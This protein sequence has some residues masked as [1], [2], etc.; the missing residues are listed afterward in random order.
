MESSTASP[1]P[2][3][4]LESTP[5]AEY[6]S[7]IS[8]LDSTPA[9]CTTEYFSWRQLTDLSEKVPEL[10]ERFGPVTASF[11]G[12]CVAL[13]TESGAVAVVDY[14]GRIK[15]VLA[16]QSSSYGA[17][18]AV[19]FSADYTMLVAGYAQGFVAVWDW[20]KGT[21]VSVSRPLQ[22]TDKADVVGHPAGVAVTGVQFIGTSKHRYISCSAGGSVFYHHIVR[23][24]LTT[25]STKQ[26]SSIESSAD[27]LFEAAPLPGGSYICETDGL[28][29]VA[30]LSSSSVAVLKTR[31]GVEQ[32]YRQSYQRPRRPNTATHPEAAGMRTFAK[33][34]YSG[35]VSWLPALKTKSAATATDP[36]ENVY[37]LPRLLFSWGPHIC[38][39]SAVLDHAVAENGAPLV[40]SRATPRVK[41]EQT[42]EWGAIEDVVFCRW[43][44]AETFL[45]MTRTQRLF[46]FE[47]KLH[48]ETEICISPPGIIAGRPWVT[49]ATGNEAEPSY[50]QVMNVYR[51]RVFSLC[52]ATSVYTGR[53]LSWTERLAL[54]LDQGH[55]ID[56]ITLATGLFHGDTG[57][58]VVGLPRSRRNGDSNERRRHSL[59]GNKLAELMRSALKHMFGGEDTQTQGQRLVTSPVS[60]TGTASGF[61]FGYGFESGSGSGSGS[62]RRSDS[63]MRALVSACI[64]ACLATDTM[65]ILFG[66]VYECYAGS[67][68]GLCAY[69]ETLEPFILCGRVTQLP[70]QILNAFIDA[71]GST[72]QMVRRLGEILMNLRLTQGDFDIDRVLGSCRRYGLWRTFARVWLGLGDP[73]TPVNSMV[74]ALS[75]K[76][77]GDD[78]TSSARGSSCADFRDARES[79]EVPEV[80]LYD[81]IDMVLRGRH[82][83]DGQPIRPQSRAEKYSTQIAELVLLPADKWSSSGGGDGGGGGTHSEY[84]VLLTLLDIDTERF[85]L[86]LKRVLS[87]PF[88]DYINLIIKPDLAALAAGGRMAKGSDRSLRRASQVKSFA[89][90]V[91][92]TFYALTVEGGSKANHS[93]P[94]ELL[95]KH[96]V[97]LLSSFA[98]TLYST[99][100]PLIFLCD[101]KVTVWTDLLLQL[102]DPTTLAEREYAFELMFKLNPPQSSAAWVDR[103]R[104]A[105]FFRVLEDI[106]Q[107]MRRYDLALQTYLD[108]PDFM[109]HRQVFAAIGALSATREAPALAD[110]AKFVR[111]RAVALVDIDAEGLVGVVESVEPLSHD[112]L[113]DA[114]ESDSKAQYAYLRALLDPAP[115]ALSRSTAALSRQR[116]SLT[117]VA[118]AA[119]ERSPP[120]IGL[121]DEQ[122]AV[123][124]PFRFLAPEG[125]Q[126]PNKFPPKYHERYLELLCQYNPGG[127]LGYLK[128]HADQSPEP[129]Q[130][131]H[132][133]AICSKHGVNDGLVWVLVRLGDFSGAL[134]TL[135]AQTDLVF[136][137]AKA[138]IPVDQ[139]SRADVAGAE[140]LSE[141][142][143]ER[144]V[145]HLNAASRS[146]GGCV[147][148][149]KAALA[150]LS[151]DVAALSARRPAG[152]EAV[153]DRAASDQARDDAA[154]ARSEHRAQAG[155]QLCDLWLLL[156]K[157]VLAYLH[158]TG[159]RLDGLPGD[160]AVC[161]RE[162]LQL[163]SKRQRWMLHDILDVL[164]SAASPAASLI[165]LRHIIQQLLRAEDA[166]SAADPATALVAR[167]RAAARSLDIAEIQHLLAVAVGAYKAEARLMA[168]TNVLVDHDLFTTVAQLVRAQKQGWLVS[169]DAGRLAAQNSSGSVA[170]MARNG[171]GGGLCCGAC[172]L[173]LF[174]DRRHSAAMAGWR[175][176]MT[177]YFESSSMRVID[178]HVFEDPAAQWQWI[179]LR[180]ASANYDEF[181][182]KNSAARHG[183]DGTGCGIGTGIGAHGQQQESQQVV[184]FKCG[185]GFHRAC[186]PASPALVCLRCSA[187]ATRETAAA[188]C[189]RDR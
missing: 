87:D 158:D 8:N 166:A 103:V 132:V 38:V 173:Q 139:E 167:P 116:S 110:I 107:G 151:R 11:M 68:A 73:V 84:R 54:L 117:A 168:L 163:I 181:R 3:L 92:D 15:T 95:S 142:D 170:G 113:F 1:M 115:E 159:R 149:C 119:D 105:G 5:E 27:V 36:A 182:S 30:I 51:R 189:L 37:S 141:A 138:A 63:E 45:Y 61:G 19:S 172:N 174:V 120:D 186:L 31:N 25:M 20:A 49:L 127:V 70:P 75:N 169:A 34:P 122:H 99:R 98:L 155:A 9:Q 106:Y 161:T 74:Q 28:G 160:C 146:I 13:G 18:S 43:I 121:S 65:P 126:T 153:S 185:H 85:L 82:Y 67:A 143:R 2:A 102:D 184:L 72:P 50:A 4:M 165:S 59:V 16:A 53:L 66:E 100:F 22:P 35:S 48:Q 77:T 134:S 26:V 86:T 71:Y 164:I 6:E 76:G 56:A 62:G 7:R 21:T 109:Y 83:P 29:L 42:L 44:D 17:V 188:G 69:L 10:A 145:D 24:L 130:L 23:R 124:Y 114:L 52:G 47:T 175:R 81:Y 129:F 133:Q 118:A 14:L 88:L 32:L 147:D 154:R 101:S 111:N 93:S 136:E 150:T 180:S 91:V 156:L 157:R 55:F 57:Q 162:A 60:G 58:V 64:E 46:V 90:M 78:G 112:A 12:D 137:E 176:H 183:A 80:V 108:H 131:S 39:L 96:Q 97:G 94:A 79:E 177:Q 148:V 135:L 40:D 171:A 89:Q 144:L 140:A 125:D 128:G 123:I 152:P 179:K 104:G 187:A 178:L 41:F 33:R